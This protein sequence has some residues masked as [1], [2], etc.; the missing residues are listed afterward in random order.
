MIALILPH[1][2]PLTKKSPFLRVPVVTIIVATGPL[3]TSILDYKTTPVAFDSK[4]V[5]KSRISA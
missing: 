1:L 4:S 3:L 5:F 2:D